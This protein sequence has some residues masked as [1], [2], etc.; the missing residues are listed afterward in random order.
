MQ[1]HSSVD[2][3]SPTGPGGLPAPRFMGL[4][5]V[6]V[7]L[8]LVGSSILISITFQNAFVPAPL[9]VRGGSVYTI[10]LVSAGTSW[11]SNSAGT[12][13]LIVKHK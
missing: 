10:P 3:L 12:P 6:G 7:L 2:P 11:R 13:M 9:L 4:L 8:A 1:L 5:I